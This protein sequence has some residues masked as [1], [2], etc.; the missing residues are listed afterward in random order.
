M[1][2]IY[3]ASGSRRS[4]GQ[5]ARTKA[6]RSYPGDGSRKNEWKS[7]VTAFYSAV[8]SMAREK[9]PHAPS[10]SRGPCVLSVRRPG[11]ERETE[12]NEKVSLAA[13]PQ[14]QRGSSGT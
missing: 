13:T 8:T 3:I 9:G 2:N 14:G 11:R 4:Q 10:H 7:A 12:D 6:R 1:K 5:N